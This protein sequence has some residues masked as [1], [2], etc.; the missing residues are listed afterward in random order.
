MLAADHSQ[1]VREATGI[2][3]HVDVS[4]REVTVLIAGITQVFDVGPT[5]SCQLHGE[6]VKLRLLLPRDTV[7]ITYTGEGG[8]LVAHSLFVGEPGSST[9]A[10]AGG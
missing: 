6:R 10:R 1:D 9:T 4:R 8:N 7:R 5:C 3:Q 2:I